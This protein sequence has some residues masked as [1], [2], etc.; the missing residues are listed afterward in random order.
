[1]SANAANAIGEKT[2]APISDPPASAAPSCFHRNSYA[3]LTTPDTTPKQNPSIP[4]RNTHDLREMVA[5]IV[6]C[7]LCLLTVKLRGRTTTPDER[8]GRTLSPRAR[9]DTTAPHG[10][11]QRLLGGVVAKYESDQK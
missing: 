10:P 11:L 9:G 1:M 4:P 7:T 3:A 2:S 8:R 5:S 6:F